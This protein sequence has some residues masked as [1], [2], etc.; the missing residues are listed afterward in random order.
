MTQTCPFCGQ[1]L[2][3]HAGDCR[4]PMDLD[5]FERVH[6]RLTDARANAPLRRNLLRYLV[7]FG[8]RPDPAFST[9]P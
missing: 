8:R 6:D 3:H 9:A 5:R 2:P 4:V 1:D 7:S